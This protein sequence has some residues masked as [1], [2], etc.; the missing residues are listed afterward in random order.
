MQCRSIQ[1]QSE[2]D[3]AKV[4]GATH[5]DSPNTLILVF[6]AP[7]LSSQPELFRT[8]RTKFPQSI[9][10]GCS[11]AGEICGREIR[12][13]TLTLLVAK[14]ER[15]QLHARV[16]LDPPSTASIPYYQAFAATLQQSNLKGLLVLSEGLA[17]NGSQVARGLSIGNSN[18][19]PIA[20]GLAADGDRFQKTYLLWNGEI[21]TKGI[22]AVGFSGENVSVRSSS[23]GGWD[24]FGPRRIV[25]KSR[26][27]IVYE[28]DGKPALDLYKSY[29][30]EKA[31]G[32]P[33]SG[34]LFPLKVRQL[35][36]NDEVVRT[37]LGLDEA[38]RS[39]RFAGDVP[40]GASCQLMKANFNRLV[41]AASEAG[42]ASRTPTTQPGDRSFSVAISCV[43]RRLV[44]R[45][46]AE[47]ELDALHEGMDATEPVVGFYSYGEIGS[48][49]AGRP[50]E[51]HNQSMTVFRITEHEP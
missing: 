27:N 21:H 36:S 7:E 51:L 37:L 38:Q 39:L 40:E 3:W 26:G 29:L 20:G 13:H 1:W 10:V 42:A 8:L 47:E 41:S 32:L 2:G 14:L 24:I 19:L 30:G 34:L 15:G 16:D 12:D 45:D 22:A 5:L 6:F 43:G 9:V 17:T 48:L 31:S 25:T 50:C 35:D 33:A 28:F 44:L 11:T 18:A 46:R 23:R 49:D 4:E